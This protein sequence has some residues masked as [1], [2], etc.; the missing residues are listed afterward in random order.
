[1]IRILI[2]F[3]I[4]GS[5]SGVRPQE[6]VGK[7]ATV[8]G[9]RLHYREMGRGPTVVLVHGLG[10]DGTRWERNIVPLSRNFR[11]IA[12]DQIGFGQ[13]DKP[14]ANYNNR[15]LSE[16]LVRFL[17]SIE[18]TKATLIGNSMGAQVALRVAVQHPEIVGRLVLV[19]GG[20]VRS[21]GTSEPQPMA[22]ERQRIMNGV[23]SEEMRELLGLLIHDKNLITDRMIDETLMTHLQ[24]SY[25]IGKI[26][27]AGP[28]LNSLSEEE[29]RTVKSPTLIIWGKNDALT[30]PAAGERLAKV[31][32]GSRR[33]VIDD[34]GHMPQW[35]RPNEFNRVV[36]EFLKDDASRSS[37][38]K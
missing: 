28:K 7:N 37:S 10:A 5:A 30:G 34:A 24:S 9:F 20:N 17:S 35:E 32:P 18:V 16:F 27:E 25:A 36:A 31:I 22:P 1:M 3:I 26:L 21:A 15:M 38:R 8:L 19:D 12:L 11:V 4:L 33:V 14:M 23:T 29:V 2:A 6:P 13:S